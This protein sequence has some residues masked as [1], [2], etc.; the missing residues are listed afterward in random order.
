[1]SVEAMGVVVVADGKQWQ[2]GSASGTIKPPKI[3]RKPGIWIHR[4]P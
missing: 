3:C 1:M 4:L 2:R